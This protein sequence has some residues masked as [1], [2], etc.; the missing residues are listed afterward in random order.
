[1]FDNRVARK[2]DLL[3]SVIAVSMKTVNIVAGLPKV[4]RG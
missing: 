1:M 4:E 2:L 3:L